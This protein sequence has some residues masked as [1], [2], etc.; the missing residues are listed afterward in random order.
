M[1]RVSPIIRIAMPSALLTADR[2]EVIAHL[3]PSLDAA[4]I[5]LRSAVGKCWL[6]R[7]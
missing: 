1:L 7:P 6:A 2:R 4:Q 5:A 3:Q